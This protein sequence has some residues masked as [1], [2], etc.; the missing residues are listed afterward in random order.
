M[1]LKLFDILDKSACH[2]LD[3]LEVSLGSHFGDIQV[4]E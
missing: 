1:Q 3:I 2:H 4:P